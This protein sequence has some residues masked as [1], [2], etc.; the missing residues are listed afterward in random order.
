MPFATMVMNAKLIWIY[1]LFQS[2]FLQYGKIYY[3]GLV[4]YNEI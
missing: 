4:I 1:T 3:K 2:S